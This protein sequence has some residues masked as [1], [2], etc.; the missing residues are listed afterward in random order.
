MDSTA[1]AERLLSL[2][3]ESARVST[4]KSAL[5]LAIVDRVQEHIGDGRLPVRDLAERVVELYWPQTLKYPTTGGV[6]RQVQEGEA[7]IVTAVTAFRGQLGSELR[8]LPQVHRSG[9][10]WEQLLSRVEEKLAEF[11]IPRLQK[12]FQPFL[13]DFDWTWE[14]EGKWSVRRYRSSSRMLMLHD[15]VAETLVSLGPLLRPFIVR[16][17]TDKAAQ[18]NPRVEAA[19]SLIKF[20]D[21]LFGRDRVALERVAESLLDLQRGV[22]FYCGSRIAR[23]REID[24]F[25]PWS[26]SGDDG[27]DNLVAACRTCNNDKRATLPGASHLHELLSRNERWFADLD[28]IATERQWP[29]NHPRSLAIVRVAYLTG[30]TDRLL[31]RWDRAARRRA[32]APLEGDRLHLERLLAAAMDKDALGATLESQPEAS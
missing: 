9:P 6:L 29:R 27:L 24:H 17:W 7:V 14:A 19:R 16:W 28:S 5:L 13:Y 12:P 18:L 32:L 10:E 2:L 8:A 15:G 26:R 1:L 20:E 4:Y 21:F 22:C 30:S 11:P 3:V 25:V 23:D 31:W